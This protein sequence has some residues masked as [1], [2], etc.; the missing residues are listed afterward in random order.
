MNKNERLVRS[1]CL[2]YCTYY[3]AGTN[4]ELRCRG[5]VIAERLILAGRWMPH[6]KYAPVDLDKQV[7]DIVADRLC[8]KCDFRLNDCDFA[9][10]RAAPPC[11]GFVLI[12]RMISMKAISLEEIE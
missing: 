12:S 9:L 6:E 7:I 4:D 3:K 5:A 2:P 8:G 1:L 11:G 10:D